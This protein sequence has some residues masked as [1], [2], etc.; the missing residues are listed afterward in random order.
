MLLVHCTRG[1]R[2]WFSESTMHSTAFNSS[3][4]QYDTKGISRNGRFT[5]KNTRI[6]KMESFVTTTIT[7][8]STQ[9][10]KQRSDRLPKKRT[11]M[12]DWRRVITPSL[13]RVHRKTN[14]K[15]VA[16]LASYCVYDDIREQHET[17]HHPHH[18]RN[19]ALNARI[20]NQQ[21]PQTNEVLTTSDRS[22]RMEKAGT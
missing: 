13:I 21:T 2:A 20:G 19:Y 7:K 9:H 16:I 8:S 3:N 22:D 15:I 4:T 14:E 18:H 6:R 10:N 17:R 5:N 11:T 12:Y 1:V